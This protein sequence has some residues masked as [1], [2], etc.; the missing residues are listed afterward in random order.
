MKVAAAP[1][2]QLCVVA[3]PDIQRGDRLRGGGW[4]VGSDATLLL[5]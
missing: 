5:H 4:A 2:D 1:A 3:S